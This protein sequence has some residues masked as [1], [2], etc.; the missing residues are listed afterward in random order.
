M[1]AAIVPRHRKP[2]KADVL[3]HPEVFAHVGL[4][5]NEPPGQAGLPFIKSSDDFESFADRSRKL[6][7]AVQPA[8]VLLYVSRNREQSQKS[9]LP[10]ALWTGVDIHLTNLLLYRLVKTGLILTFQR[11]VHS[12]PSQISPASSQENARK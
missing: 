6:H 1:V 7:Y 4:L 11:S 2:K 3:E 8:A 12:I 10:A 9:C 5:F